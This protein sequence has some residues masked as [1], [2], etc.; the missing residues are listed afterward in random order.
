MG[1]D[2]ML[3]CCESPRDDKKAMPFIQYRVDNLSNDD[4]DTLAEEL[5][6]YDSEEIASEVEAECNLTKDDLWKLDDLV[7]I[8]IRGM[9][10]EKVMEAAEAL[11]GESAYRRDAAEVSL[12]DRIYMMTG[13]MSWGDLPT[14]AC[15]IINL[16]AHS[17]VTDGMSRPDFDYE[18]F[19]A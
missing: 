10:K 2:F 7:N 19:K 4:L 17:R 9:V 13:G 3:Y 5:L 12:H 1:A 16:I 14:E 6:W 15:D 18:S 8:K 11:F